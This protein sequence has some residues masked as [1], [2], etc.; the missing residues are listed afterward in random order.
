MCIT[1]VSNHL[2]HGD[3]HCTILEPWCTLFDAASAVYLDLA[4]FDCN[5]RC[6]HTPT[7]LQPT[8]FQLCLRQGVLLGAGVCWV[9]A[10]D[11]S[12]VYMHRYIAAAVTAAACCM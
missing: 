6:R 10:A 4:V 5:R 9:A 12:H 2:L 7:I 3:G 1:H 11:S 8:V